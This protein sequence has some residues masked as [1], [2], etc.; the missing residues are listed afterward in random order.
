MTEALP[1]ICRSAI[2]GDA[3]GSARWRWVVGL[4]FEW[5]PGKAAANEGKRGV[6]FEEARTV[7]SDVLSRTIP[8][9]DHSTAEMRALQLGLS[10]SGRLLVVAFTERNH[11]I[12]IISARLATLRERH[13][14]EENT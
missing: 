8:D 2:V 6:S 7:F 1:R 13:D 4:V 10:Q 5:D 3:D 14:Y 11:R 12:R 9:P